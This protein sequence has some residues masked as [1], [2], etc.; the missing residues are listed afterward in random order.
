MFEHRQI[1]GELVNKLEELDE[2]SIDLALKIKG[3][4]ERGIKALDKRG[5]ET[6]SIDDLHEA[7]KALGL[8]LS[9]VTCE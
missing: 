1:I 4:A 5:L 7:Q 8:I 6:P 9:A 2:S 3:L